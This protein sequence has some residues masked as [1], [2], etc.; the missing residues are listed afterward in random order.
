MA[1]KSLCQSTGNHLTEPGAKRKF[2]GLNH[3]EIDLGQRN[4]LLIGF[5]QYAQ[6]QAHKNVDSVLRLFMDDYRIVE[7]T[8]QR[9]T[10]SAHALFKLRPD[11]R[12]LALR[13]APQVTTDFRF[14]DGE[15]PVEVKTKQD[16]LQVAWLS[17][18]AREISTDFAVYFLVNNLRDLQKLLSTG[19]VNAKVE[20]AL[21]SVRGF[22]HHNLTNPRYAFNLLQPL[23]GKP[24]F[25]TPGLIGDP[26]LSFHPGIGVGLIR[27]QWVPS[28]NF[29]LEIVPTR[30]QQ[31]GYFVGYT[32]NFFFQSATDQSF[33]TFRN[34]FVHAG[35][36]FYRKDKSSRTSNFSKQIGSFY[37]GLPVHRSDP[38]FAPNTIKL[39]GT[40]YQNGLF[41]VQAD[42]YMNGFFKQVNPSLRL[43]VGF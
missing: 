30:F 23:T 12:D 22:K 43:V 5:D 14:R 18:S 29:D 8:T 16:T 20:Q 24:T 11:N 39:G 40:I 1:G 27:N 32:S 7:D 10:R 19:G 4:T 15:S 37:V 25:Q 9:P 33:Q 35:V 42:I 21:E 13:S 26:F 36:S 6:V 28:F 3:I 41:K 31:V 38:Y 2:I 17:T 34:D